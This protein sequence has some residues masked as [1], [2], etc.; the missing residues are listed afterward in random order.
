[1]LGYGGSNDAHNLAQ[2]E[3]DALGVATMMRR[4]L[5]RAGIERERVGYI[6]AHG[7]ATPAR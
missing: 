6:N 5:E 7:T 1:M 4:A 3:P 2:P